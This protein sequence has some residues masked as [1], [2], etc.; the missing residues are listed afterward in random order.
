MNG[1]LD[2]KY[3]NAQHT[4]Q[5][6]LTCIAVLIAGILMTGCQ[7][8]EEKGELDRTEKIIAFH[9]SVISV[10]S[11]GTP[12]TKDD[13]TSLVSAGVYAYFTGTGSFDEANSTPDYMNNQLIERSRN[14]ST[15]TEWT[16]SP[17]RLWPPAGN[18]LTFL[19]YAPNDKWC[20]DLTLSQ[21]SGVAYPQM[22]FTVNAT[23]KEQVDL[24]IAEPAKDCDRANGATVPLKMQHALTLISFSAAV[25]DE[26]TSGMMKVNKITVANVL[27][28]GSTHLKTPIEWAGLNAT[29]SYIL[30][31]E[32]GMLTGT[33]LTTTMSL[34][35]K[36][37][38]FLLLMPQPF[39]DE[40][41][42]IIVE[43]SDATGV[44]KIYEEDFPIYYT[45]VLWEPGRSINYR[46]LLDAK[47]V[48]ITAGLT[49][50]GDSKDFN[51]GDH[52]GGLLPWE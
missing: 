41:A 4:G 42:K 1:L 2:R 7:T 50:W 39:N 49:P 24:L 11:R 35:N 47:M 30:S 33:A 10:L 13:Q 44:G 15:F 25:K 19:A 40:Q 48:E 16:Y 37:D 51:G 12:I 8:S 3:G 28:S 34:Q 18:K 45:E 26:K 31:V 21:Q 5:Y 14:E 43:Y 36:A 29:A 23:I 20:S 52:P 22:G 17:A 38:G 46:I 9:S 27:S 6:L 32:N